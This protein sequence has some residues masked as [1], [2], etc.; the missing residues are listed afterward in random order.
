MKI[1]RQVMHPKRLFRISVVNGL[2]ILPPDKVLRFLFRLERWLYYFQGQIASRYGKGEHPK[3]RLTRYH[4]FFVNRVQYGERVL[5]L[6][7]GIGAVANDIADQAEASV[8]GMDINPECIT[9]ARRRYGHTRIE[10]VCGDILKGVPQGDFEVIVLSNI[11][12]HLKNRS[13][14]LQRLQSQIQPSRFLIRVPLFERDWRVPLMK[15]LGV[16]W[17]LDPTHEIEYS[18]ETFAQE[19]QEAGLEV[20]YQEVRWGE[21]WAEVSTS[22]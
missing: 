20:R 19:I 9:E 11:L 18:L 21:I 17:R 1:L 22:Q 3:H 12:E 7:C 16:E 4:D 6:G 15:E 13:E 10:F 2:K 8:V 5:D 14:F